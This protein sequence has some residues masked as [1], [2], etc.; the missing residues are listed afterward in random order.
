[1]LLLPLLHWQSCFCSSR[2]T[3]ILFMKSRRSFVSKISAQK[4]IIWLLSGP[5]YLENCTLLSPVGWLK[6][7]LIC[8][9]G[10]QTLFSQLWTEGFVLVHCMYLAMESILQKEE[11]TRINS[12]CAQITTVETPTAIKLLYMCQQK[13]KTMSPLVV[14]ILKNRSNGK[15]YWTPSSG[16][17]CCMYP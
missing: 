5:Y 7:S 15:R 17:S 2:W 14:V 9:T 6:R 16:H 12:R 3:P 8:A 10:T 1:M 11:P 4:V 13:L